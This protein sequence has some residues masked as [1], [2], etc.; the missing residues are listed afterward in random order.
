MGKGGR[1]GVRWDRAAAVGL[2]LAMAPLGAAAAASKVAPPGPATIA[3]MPVRITAA[4]LPLWASGTNFRWITRVLFEPQ[5]GRDV[6]AMSRGYRVVGG[7]FEIW[8]PALAPGWYR[9]VIQNRYGMSNRPWVRV[10]PTA[11]FRPHWG[12]P[13]T[14]NGYTVRGDGGRWITCRRSSA[15]VAHWLLAPR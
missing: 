5:H 11:R 2:A 12:C 1:R 6:Y 4:S 13:V 10:Y 15:T 3:S 7:R 8:T 14:W 9:M